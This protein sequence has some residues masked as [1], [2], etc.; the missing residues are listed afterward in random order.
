MLT[1]VVGNYPKIAN[2]RE[3]DAAK[4]APAAFN[5]N[6]TSIT[7]ATATDVTTLPTNLRR[8]LALFDEGKLTADQLKEVQ[9]NVTIEVIKEQEAAGVDI[10]TDGHIRWADD[11]TYI[12]G[13]VKGF[14]L[15]GLL[16]YFDSN[17]YYR[18]PVAEGKLSADGP[19]LLRD[20]QFA[21]E[22]ASKPV[23]VSMDGPYTLARL[24]KD[25]HYKSDEDFALALAE[26]L[27]NEAKALLKAGAPIVQFDEPAILRHKGDFAMF[28]RVMKRL[29]DGLDQSKLALYTYFGNTDGLD[30]YFELPFA[31][32]GIDL[33]DDYGRDSW[34]WLNFFPKG[35]TLGAGIVDARNTRL[36]SVAEI[37][38]KINE[39]P[40]NI[41][42][43]NVQVSPNSGLEFLPRERAQEK[44]AR[45]VEAVR[46]VKA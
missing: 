43:A 19:I 39:L 3:S 9:D 1:T 29:T 13:K 18:Q 27:N 24:S 15:S 32:F 45:M 23:K 2:R 35:K 36:E 46:S 40:E 5:P 12:A 42:R 26:I 11:Q 14:T 41:D 21:A 7:T 30:H 25:E 44:L 20:Y 28:A 22:H 31:I 33:T 17:T 38:A 8:A 10:I 6:A 16:R 37:V 4:A 34:A